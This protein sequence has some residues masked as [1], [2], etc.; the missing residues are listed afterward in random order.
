MGARQ[1]EGAPLRFRAGAVVLQRAGLEREAE[2]PGARELLVG[3]ERMCQSRGHVAVGIALLA[4]DAEAVAAARAEAADEA[5]LA[6]QHPGGRL[7]LVVQRVAGVQPGRLGI[8]VGSAQ[9]R[10]DTVVAAR[11]L[12]LGAQPVGQLDSAACAGAAV[13]VARVGRLRRGLGEAVGV[14][15]RLG[16]VIGAHGDVRA[17]PLRLRVGDDRRFVLA[18]VH[19]QPG[20]D[21]PAIVEAMGEVELDRVGVEPVVLRAVVDLAAQLGAGRKRQRQRP[22]RLVGVPRGRLSGGGEARIALLQ[23]HGGVAAGPADEVAQV[24]GGLE[25]PGIGVG[26]LVDRLVRGLETEAAVVRQ[27]GRRADSRGPRPL[28]PHPGPGAVAPGEIHARELLLGTGLLLVVG[29]GAELDAVAEP[30]GDAAAGGD[31]L[32][33]VESGRVFVAR[34]QEHGVARQRAAGLHQ[35]TAVRGRG[36]WRG[37]D[38]ATLDRVDVVVLAGDQVVDLEHEA[39]FQVAYLHP[40][41]FGA[42]DDVL[43]LEEEQRAAGAAELLARRD[44]ARFRAERVHLRAAFAE[45]RRAAA[46]EVAVG[47]VE[48]PVDLGEIGVENL[49]LEVAP[50]A[51]GAVL[52]RLDVELARGGRV[53]DGRAVVAEGRLEPVLVQP[54]EQRVGILV[55]EVAEDL[56]QRSLARVGAAGEL[57]GIVGEAVGVEGEPAVDP[58][59]RVVVLIVLAD[60]PGRPVGVV[61]ARGEIGD[62]DGVPVVG[63]D[64]QIAQVDVAV[65]AVIEQGDLQRVQAARDDALDHE[66]ALVIE[67]HRLAQH[68]RRVAVRDRVAGH[69]DGA[70]VERDVL[71]RD[72]GL[73]ERR[74]A[75]AGGRVGAV[76]GPGLV[77]VVHQPQ[78]LGRRFVK[79]AVLVVDP[80]HV[81][82]APFHAGVGKPVGA[83]VRAQRHDVERFGPH[84]RPGRVQPHLGARLE[85]GIVAVGTEVRAVLHPFGVRVVLA[86]DGL[87][88][89]DD[90]QAAMRAT[91][92]VAHLHTRGVECR[93][94]AALDVGRVRRLVLVE[95]LAVDRDAHRRERVRRARIGIARDLDQFGDPVGIDR[96]R[97]VDQDL[98]LHPAVSHLRDA[99]GI[100]RRRLAEALAGVTQQFLRQVRALGHGLHHAPCA[101]LRQGASVAVD[102]RRP[103]IEQ[104]ALGVTG[105]VD[106]RV[107]PALL[108]A[109]DDAHQAL[110]PVVTELRRAVDERHRLQRWLAIRAIRLRQVLAGVAVNGTGLDIAHRGAAADRVVPDLDLDPPVERPAPGGVVRR[111]RL[112]RAPTL[113]H[114][115]V[116]AQAEALARG[117][118]HL[119]GVGPRQAGGIAVALAREFAQAGGVGMADEA[120]AQVRCF[121]EL[122]EPALE[123]GEGAGR[124]FAE[125][126]GEADG[127]DDVAQLHDFDIAPPPLEHA[128]RFLPADAYPASLRLGHVAFAGAR[129]L[130]IPVPGADLD[131]PVAAAAVGGRGIGDRFARA[132]AF[133][134]HGPGRQAEPAAHVG[135]DLLGVEFRQAHRT[136]EDL[137]LRLAERGAVGVA[138]EM[139]PQALVLPQVFEHAFQRADALAVDQGRAVVAEPDR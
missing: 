30:V 91:V 82:E 29:G 1:A 105:E 114:D 79:A 66:S 67:R 57:P 68:P 103:S 16:R 31:L 129:P 92:V 37:E 96:C 131:P 33:L 90:V 102:Q 97:H 130:R 28:E 54:P 101:D 134:G 13:G 104:F 116:L 36:Q 136:A 46:L 34:N 62:A 64:L 26:I 120:H 111:Q 83:A 77:E 47:A 95:P 35:R 27:Q 19:A 4:V 121:R 127:R 15:V 48:A 6:L 132:R 115:L 61:D 21:F 112:G 53:L 87:G 52:L 117:L 80:E 17:P 106:P 137:R 20:G 9:L 123:L 73:V 38:H 124:Q 22:A 60:E 113:E 14:P 24:G 55:H 138:D 126:S 133:P 12:A 108:E 93:V 122:V 10:A 94:G 135:G 23:V 98:G 70:A 78:S 128:G 110:Q 42:L 45:V 7:A 125:R 51:E 49:G 18:L 69:R 3:A 25:P 8:Q 44:R 88:I 56:V 85:L 76:A 72:H 39:G 40:D 32:E 99:E 58:G 71:A 119:A 139:Q 84:R 50:H 118:G 86:G 81:L 100:V 75:A 43:V 74:Q 41:P 11:Q 65:A 63:A 59:L 89:R 2:G 109:V 107:L 5:A